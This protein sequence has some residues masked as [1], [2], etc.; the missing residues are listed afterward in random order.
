M[1]SRTPG[2]RALQGCGLPAR[3][4]SGLGVATPVRTVNY[5]DLGPLAPP[6]TSVTLL[7]FSPQPVLGPS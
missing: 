2:G 7:S 4:G 1:E 6:V 5:V 3:L